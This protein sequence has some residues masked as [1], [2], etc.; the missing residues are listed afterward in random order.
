MLKIQPCM[1]LAEFYG[2]VFDKVSDDEER[3]AVM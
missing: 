3:M 1:H 2:G